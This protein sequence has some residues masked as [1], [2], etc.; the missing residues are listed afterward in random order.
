MP[1][2]A[3]RPEPL[4]V[5]QAMRPLHLAGAPARNP[6]HRAHSHPDDPLDTA[7]QRMGEAGVDEV[8]VVS[9]TGGTHS[10]Y[11]IFTML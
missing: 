4:T 8:L 11:S 6:M 9:R 3:H 7:L 1:S 2:A 10:A 5:E